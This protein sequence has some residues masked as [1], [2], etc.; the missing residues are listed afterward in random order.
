MRIRKVFLILSIIFLCGFIFNIETSK[1]YVTKTKSYTC[2][3]DAYVSDRWL[4]ENY[5]NNTFLYVGYIYWGTEYSLSFL[6]FNIQNKPYQLSDIQRI[7]LEIHNSNGQ[8]IES[9][10]LLSAYTTSS[11]WEEYIITYNNMPYPEIYI[12]SVFVE[13]RYIIY[14]FEIHWW[15]LYEDFIQNDL[16]SFCFNLSGDVSNEAFEFMSREWRDGERTPMLYVNY[17][18]EESKRIF[19]YIIPIFISIIC[20]SVGVNIY[21]MVKKEG[22]SKKVVK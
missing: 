3:E 11:N 9:P 13:Q 1:A 19:G 12:G 2:I 15:N 18:A 22:I 7:Y 10:F 8:D 16:F 14:H 4:N 21:I 6:K 20:L 17:E 5:G